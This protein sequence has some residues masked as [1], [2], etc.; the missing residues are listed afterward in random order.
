MGKLPFQ[1]DSEKINILKNFL[2]KLNILEP[3]NSPDET[4]ITHM[5]PEREYTLDNLV[6]I[7]MIPEKLV[8][9]KVLCD[10]EFFFAA[11]Q[12][13][14]TIKVQELLKDCLKSPL[15]DQ[16]DQINKGLTLACQHGHLTLIPLLLEAGANGLQ[17][18]PTGLLPLDMLTSQLQDLVLNNF[19]NYDSRSRYLPM[20]FIGGYLN[21]IILLIK[22]GANPNTLNEK[23]C[24]F[25]HILLDLF[26]KNLISF[27]FLKNVFQPN[28]FPIP[29]DIDLPDD[30]G[31]LPFQSNSEKILLLKTFITQQKVPGFLSSKDE[32]LNEGI[33]VK[34]E[35]VQQESKPR[36][37]TILVFFKA[38]ERLD[39]PKITN[40]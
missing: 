38:C 9:S 39:R 35:L 21:C 29:L 15:K 37:D 17:K 40:F 6:D 32:K 8:K 27:S 26:E 36:E 2:T 19:I 20:K 13:G 23:G 28:Y 3:F 25:L 11:C 22:Q 31:N 16:N 24:S 10:S 34:L 1:N 7:T 12:K 4:S 18:G 14:H 5:A 33:A 30:R